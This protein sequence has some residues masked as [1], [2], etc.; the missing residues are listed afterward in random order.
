M[1]EESPRGIYHPIPSFEEWAKQPLEMRFW[2]EALATLESERRSAP[3]EALQTAAEIVTR[4]A[5]VD[6][7]AIEGFYE[8]DR[9][10]TFSVATHAPTWQAA[11]DEKG[12]QAR[13]MFDAQLRAFELVLDAATTHLPVTESLVRALHE[14]VC[15]TQDTYKVWTAVGWQEHQLQKGAY[16][17]YPNN[18]RT[19][20]GVE[21]AYAPVDDVSPEMARLVAELQAESFLQAPPPVQ[22]AYAHYAF[23]SIH[24]FPDGNGRVARALASIYL[25]RAASIPLLVFA[26]QKPRYLDALADADGG[27]YAAFS[28]FVRDRSIDAINLL[29]GS[30]QRAKLAPLGDLQ[31][32][33][34]RL[35]YATPSLTHGQVDSLADRL[36][37]EAMSQVHTTFERLGFPKEIAATTQIRRGDDRGPLPGYRRLGRP[38][39]PVLEI[40]V[41]SAPPAVAAVST[42]IRPLIAREDH[43]NP[44]RLEEQKRSRH[45]DVRIEDLLPEISVMVHFRLQTW[46]ETLL[47]SMVEQAIEL[48]R[49][50]L[51]KSGWN[52]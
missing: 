40:V 4:A 12:A 9:G 19:P 44:V 33:A 26:D 32:R 22:A 46:V 28:R 36:L 42:I 17:R 13:S 30:L 48:G 41:K 6:T 1:A 35:H 23:V 10:F 25:V 5:A 15:A 43:P 24:P 47:L 39:P 8:V 14:H 18:P 20:D 34:S 38:D 2:D 37:H 7:S 16:K 45:F 50:S 21:H 31:S 29:V 51:E 27:D 3:P 52:G 49:Q 11:F